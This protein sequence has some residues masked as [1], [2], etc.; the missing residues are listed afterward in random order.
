VK[1]AR[2]PRASLF[3]GETIFLETDFTTST[4]WGSQVFVLKLLSSHQTIS[5][6]YL[7][8]DWGTN[9]K[10]IPCLPYG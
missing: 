4:P 7:I 9:S 6:K 10:F 1:Y 8:L 2:R 5:P 3:S